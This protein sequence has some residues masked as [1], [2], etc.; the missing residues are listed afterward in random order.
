MK[1]LIF[2]FAT[3]F[4]GISNAQGILKVSVSNPILRVGDDLEIKY[5]LKS[6]DTDVENN[7]NTFD[8][9]DRLNTVGQGE[10]TI[11]EFTKDTGY[12]KIDPIVL[13]FNGKKYTSD[14]I[15]IYVLPKLPQTRIGFWSHLVHLNGEIF[16]VLE[17]R[18][19]AKY[20]EERINGTLHRTLDAD[21]VDFAEIDIKSIENPHVRITF[22]SSRTQSHSLNGNSFGGDDL[23]HSKQT[24]YN[25]TYSE[26]YQFDFLLQKENFIHFPKSSVFRAI[27]LN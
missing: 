7:S 9:D 13:T 25:I 14:T 24:I 18:F 10:L 16:L 19:P 11:A 26:N 22:S 27:L 5:W 21:N 12:V 23:M 6:S 2:L 1:N 8:F 4:I 3:L 17:Q 20:K 15:N